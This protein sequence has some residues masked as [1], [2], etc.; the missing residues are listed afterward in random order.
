MADDGDQ[1]PISSGH[2]VAKAQPFAGI[3]GNN[4]SMNQVRYGQAAKYGEGSRPDR[5][6]AWRRAYGQ[7]AKM[8][9][10]HGEEVR[11]PADVRL[12]LEGARNSGRPSL[13]NVC[14]STPTSTRPD[15]STR[16]CTSERGNLHG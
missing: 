14:G 12:A 5:Q 15:P 13:I 11:D 16:P 1:V 4:S 9:G 6:H 10:D 2:L 8:L 7:F 3:V